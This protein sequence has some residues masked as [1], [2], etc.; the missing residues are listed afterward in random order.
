MG[1]PWTPGTWYPMIFPLQE[2]S[3]FHLK[4]PLLGS[5]RSSSGLSGTGSTGEVDDAWI[6]IV[7]PSQ[8]LLLPLQQQWC[9]EGEHP[10]VGP[11]TAPSPDPHRLQA[12]PIT[13]TSQQG[14]DA[15]AK[16][17]V[18]LTFNVNIPISFVVRSRVYRIVLGSREMVTL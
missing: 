5:S 9:D 12:D 13:G 7:C 8:R 17:Q 1:T 14:A 16:L 10:A 15:V 6:A 3:G 2:G 11:C 18:I 4:D